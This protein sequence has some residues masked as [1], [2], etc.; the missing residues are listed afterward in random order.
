MALLSYNKLR[1]RKANMQSPTTKFLLLFLE[2]EK[3]QG[4][5]KGDSWSAKLLFSLNSY[6]F[7]LEASDD[8]T[9]PEGHKVTLSMRWNLQVQCSAVLN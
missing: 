6:G 2:V 4:S 1:K 9:K 8:C 3:N 7:G 5:L